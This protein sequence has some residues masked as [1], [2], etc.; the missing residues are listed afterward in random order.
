VV[1]KAISKASRRVVAV[2]KVQIFGMD[3]EGR[4]E[5][6]NEARI[7][8]AL[9]EHPNIIRY[10]DS[11]IHDN[12]LFLVLELAES[13]DLCKLLDEARKAKQTF[14][15]ADIWFYFIQICDA[16]RLMHSCRVMHRDIK[17]SNIFLSGG[18][19]VKV[20][21]LGLGRYLSSKTN[22]IF[23]MVGTPFYMSP[24]AISNTGYNLKSDIWSLGCLLYEL[25]AL[26]SPFYSVNLNYYNLGSCIQSAQYPPLSVQYS[27]T[28]RDLV[29][30]MIQ[31]KPDDRPD[32]NNVFQIAF[33]ALEIFKDTAKQ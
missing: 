15:E 19:I 31:P 3:S 32:I 20:G 23:S 22:Q 26:Q 14:I 17:P 2:K 12:D 4:K 13:G 27:Q 5:C 9:P 29:T 8:Q 33:Q 6:V 18:R 24:E 1:H 30:W 11:Y 16:L 25:A 21:D 10:L 28:L 7:L